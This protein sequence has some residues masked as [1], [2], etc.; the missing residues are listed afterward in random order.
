MPVIS[1]LLCT[2][3]HTHGCPIF[4]G[5]FPV[6]GFGILWWVAKAVHPWAMRTDTH[7]P[8]TRSIIPAHKETNVFI[9]QLL[10]LIC[11]ANWSVFNYGPRTS[12]F[13][14]LMIYS[15]FWFW[16][17]SNKKSAFV[18]K[19]I[20]LIIYF[21]CPPAERSST[22]MEAHPTWAPQI[23]FCPSALEI[24]FMWAVLVKKSGGLRVT[25]APRPRTA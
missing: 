17:C 8:S 20:S 23:R 24:S 14:P 25:S 3:A 10:C 7:G 21:L 22:M 6:D 1:A 13:C 9:F 5:C 4:P 2:R 11:V 19:C 15:S 16:S 18:T 12:L